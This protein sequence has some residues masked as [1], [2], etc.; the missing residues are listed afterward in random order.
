MPLRLGR[1]L[2]PG[3][4]TAAS[5]L[6]GATVALPATARAADGAVD[7]VEAVASA[8]ANAKAPKGDQTV[9][10]ADDPHAI[11]EAGLGLLALPAAEV[12][13]VSPQECEPGE[14]SI[15]LSLFNM[16]RIGDFGFGAGIF[17]AFGLRPT[18]GSQGDIGTIGREHSR[19]YFLV[20]G[21]FRYYLPRFTGNWDWWAMATIG[22]VVVND[23]WTTEADRNPYADTAFV[24]PRAT[25]LSTEG[26]SAGLGV[27]GQWRISQHWTF[28]TRFRY[29]N[30]LLPGDREVLPTGDQASLAGRIDIF[31]FGVTGA[32]LLPL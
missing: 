3:M 25:T 9:D 16:G 8:E 24:G 22:G 31:D 19:S 10:F 14:T 29:A 23:S 30:W 26:F 4:A 27:G 2:F 17:W 1:P 18:G 5:L 32:F 6:V 12:C 28:G 20:E 13:P 11:V 15:A 7:D 21:A